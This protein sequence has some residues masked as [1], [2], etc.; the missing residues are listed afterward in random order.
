[1]MKILNKIKL[2]LGLCTSF[3]S[4]FCHGDVLIN[5]SATM[6][7]PACNIRSENNSSPLKI[8]FN[9]LNPEELNT[10][11]STRNFPVYITGCDFSKNLAI[12]L[13]PKGTNTLLYNGKKILATNIDGLGIKFNE[14]TGG[15]TRSLEMNQTQRIYPE[16]INSALYRMDLQAQ[17]VN[18]IPITQ[19]QLGKFTSS[20]TIAVTYY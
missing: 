20:V 1:M 19:L 18:S 11:I 6:I 2:L 15:T 4:L 16:R 10:S 8:N 13:N 3:V 5:V 7:S 17:L 12:I 14:I 9:T